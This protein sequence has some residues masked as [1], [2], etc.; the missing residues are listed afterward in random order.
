MAVT[1]YRESTWAEFVGANIPMLADFIN[2]FEAIVK[3]GADADRDIL[4]S[5]V[6]H[7]MSILRWATM[8]SEGRTDGSLDDVVDQLVWPLP[9]DEL[10]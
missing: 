3:I 8:E 2:R 4:N 9:L 10:G 7:E 1:T 6:R 5:M